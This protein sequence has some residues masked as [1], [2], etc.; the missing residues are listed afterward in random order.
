MSNNLSLIKSIIV[1]KNL[2]MCSGF[3]IEYEVIKN[4]EQV[5]NNIITY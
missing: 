2:K 1:W 3:E 4:D 5:I